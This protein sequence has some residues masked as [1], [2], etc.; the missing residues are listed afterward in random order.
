LRININS[1]IPVYHQVMDQIRTLVGSGAL[2][3]GSPLPAVRQLAAELEVNPNTVAKAYQLLEF[4]GTIVTR[5]RKG[6]F[7]GEASSARADAARERRL[8]EMVARLLEEAEQLG[9]KK[10]DIVSTLAERIKGQESE[11][12]PGGGQ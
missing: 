3:A 6:T 8:D 11:D 4:E 10:R 2:E 9:L 7:V 12:A 5:K 1:Q